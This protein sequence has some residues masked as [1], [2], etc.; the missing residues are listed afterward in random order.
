LE[1]VIAQT[2]V[3]EE[4]RRAFLGRAAAAML[5]A[6]GVLSPEFG[7][8]HEDQISPKDNIVSAGIAPDR[9]PPPKGIAPDQPPFPPRP[10]LSSAPD[11]VEKHVKECIAT[12]FQVE[13]NQ[14]FLSTDL[15]QDLKAT[16]IQLAGLKRQLEQ[17]YIIKLPGQDFFK[18]VP[19]VGELIKTV[20]TAVK[21]RSAQPAEP[22]PEPPPTPLGIRPGA[23]RGTRPN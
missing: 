3:P 20:Q 13:R 7:C 1:A 6:L 4:H 19:T 10:L 18:K 9:P 11:Q 12:R 2:R 5:A 22:K 17:D 21:T 23:T 15:V 14:V 16:E 8:D